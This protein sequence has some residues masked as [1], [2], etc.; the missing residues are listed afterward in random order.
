MFAIDIAAITIM[1]ND[2]HLVVRVDATKTAAWSAG[3]LSI[4]EI[5]HGVVYRLVSPS[6]E[7]EPR[8]ALFFS[9]QPDSSSS[10]R[11]IVV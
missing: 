2:D 3:P 11:N 7:L 9:L 4:L 8:Q 6:D 10:P 1:S 5:S